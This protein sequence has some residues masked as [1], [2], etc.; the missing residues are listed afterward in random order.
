MCERLQGNNTEATS[1][2]RTSSEYTSP[3]HR[4]PKITGKATTLRRH[5]YGNDW[6][7]PK[8]PRHQH[9]GSPFKYSPS[10]IDVMGGGNLQPIERC[11]SIPATFIQDMSVKC[12]RIQW[13]K[14]AMYSESS[15]NFGTITSYLTAC[16][17]RER[18]DTS[19]DCYSLYLKT[20]LLATTQT[21]DS[22]AKIIS[23]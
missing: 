13:G 12:Q 6:A 15:L 16:A 18:D 19:E 7:G 20:L 17:S 9:I 11:D 21:S 1:D 8:I 2:C 14:M 10:S 3:G 22:F 4:A 5:M 23:I